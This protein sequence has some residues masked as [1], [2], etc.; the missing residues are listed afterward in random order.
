MYDFITRK[1]HDN[2]VL[3][4]KNQIAELRSMISPFVEA[5]LDGE[6]IL[7]WKEAIKYVNLSPHGLSE[8]RRQGRIVGVKINSKEYGY[9]KRE[10][11]KYLKR[12]NRAN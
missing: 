1:E 11:D 4:L 12:Y 7:T 10:L 3:L 8:A 5:E 9:K 2:T 6:K